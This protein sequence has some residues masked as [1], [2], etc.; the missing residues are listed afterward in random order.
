MNLIDFAIFC[1]VAIVFASSGRWIA[2]VLNLE[3]LTAWQ[4]AAVV[5]SLI[6]A[7]ALLNKWLDHGALLL[8]VAGA[9]GS[10]IVGV[11]WG[12]WAVLAVI[13]TAA[14]LTAIRLSYSMPGV[15]LGAAAFSAASIPGVMVVWAEGWYRPDGRSIGR[16]VVV[17]LIF[18]AAALFSWPSYKQ[19]SSPKV[20]ADIGN[21]CSCDS[22]E[23]C[24][25][26]KGGKYCFDD[27]GKKRYLVR[28]K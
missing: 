11:S 13:G 18:S 17:A 1:S 3:I 5:V 27:S 2:K 26:P 15:V 8:L 19:P 4:G 20:D 12:K 28:D 7:G 25:G 23:V 22:K 6:L 16:W 14:G 21:S 9:M 24:I 10:A